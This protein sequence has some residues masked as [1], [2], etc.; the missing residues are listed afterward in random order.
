MFGAII[1]GVLGDK[2]VAII[3][4]LEN[5]YTFPGVLCAFDKGIVD[6]IADLALHQA[7][8]VG[9]QKQIIRGLLVTTCYLIVL[10]MLLGLVTIVIAIHLKSV[11][12]SL[13]ILRGVSE[14]SLPL[15]LLHLLAML[16]YSIIIT[17]AFLKKILRHRYNGILIV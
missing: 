2:Y 1:D 7:A 12:G 10:T 4:V 11:I 6:D 13:K 3:D 14:P 15:L 17:I 5:I 8:E 9:N 16:R